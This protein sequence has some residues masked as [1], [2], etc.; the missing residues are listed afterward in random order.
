MDFAI[1][2]HIYDRSEKE[3]FITFS[4]IEPP[5]GTP[6]DLKNLK[7]IQTTAVSKIILNPEMAENI[8]IKMSKLNYIWN[9]I[10]TEIRF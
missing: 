6:D 9:F 4:I 2:L 3:I 7:E 8:K 1:K 10:L 5:I